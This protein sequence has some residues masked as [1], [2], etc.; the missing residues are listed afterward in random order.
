MSFR[1]IYIASRAFKTLKGLVRTVGRIEIGGPMVGFVSHDILVVTGLSGPGSKGKCSPTSV[2][3]DGEHSKWFCDLAF[4]DSGGVVDYVGD[5]HCHPAF[6][7][8]PS[9]G[10]ERAMKTL[11]ESPGLTPNPVSLI[12]GSI[13]GRFK[14]YQWDR[15]AERLVP[16]PH[17]LVSQATVDG[18]MA[19][20]G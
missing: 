7:I 18:L 5:W 15:S 11:A 1:H 14:I 8:Q 6:C 4:S 20:R 16:I 13:W 10:D 19:D 9:S 3:I 2:T 12:Y 17:K